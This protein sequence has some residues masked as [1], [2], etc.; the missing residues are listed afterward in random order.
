MTRGPFTVPQMIEAI[1]ILAVVVIL[2]G[3]ALAIWANAEF[4]R[5]GPHDDEGDE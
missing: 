3:C 1:G 5:H 4:K 2:F